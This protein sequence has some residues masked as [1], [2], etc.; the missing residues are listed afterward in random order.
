MRRGPFIIVSGTNSL[1]PSTGEV[2]YPTS[3]YHQ[4]LRIF[5]EI[6]AAVEALKGSKQDIV[7]VR[8]FV[9]VE[10]HITSVGK[11]LK[12]VLGEVG[13]AATMI[14]GAKFISSKMLVEIE[15]DAVVN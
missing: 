14:V 3:A 12:E 13:P 1:D 7:R 8:V 5:T 9:T 6:F 10:S 15:A 11:A 2:L 4:A